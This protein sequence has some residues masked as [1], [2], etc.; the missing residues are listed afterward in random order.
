MVQAFLVIVHTVLPLECFHD[1]RVKVVPSQRVYNVGSLKAP[2]GRKQLLFSLRYRRCWWT[3]RGR[4]LL[5]EI[6]MDFFG[7][8]RD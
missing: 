3:D 4:S 2:D 5:S 6:L 7:L 8:R 1:E